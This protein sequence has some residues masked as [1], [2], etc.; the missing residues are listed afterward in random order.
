MAISSNSEATPLQGSEQPGVMIAGFKLEGFM[1]AGFK[2]LL[3]FTLCSGF[4]VLESVVAMVI[5]RYIGLG[6]FTKITTSALQIS[7]I[8][9][10]LKFSRLL[11]TFF[12]TGHH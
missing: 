10:S 5:C 9:V 4:Y 8:F 3:L 12:L 7:E 1:L 11:Y 2:R 6:K